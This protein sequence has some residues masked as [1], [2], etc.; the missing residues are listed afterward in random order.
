M[1]NKKFN[2]FALVMIVIMALFSIYSAVGKND[3][4][5]GRDGM[6]AY[7]RAVELGEFSGSEFEYLQSLHGKNGSN[8]TL[9]DVYE[10]YIKEKKYSKDDYTFSD[11]VL[12]F[13]P[14]EILDADETATLV[15]TST[16]SALRSTVDICYSFY[17]NNAIVYVEEATDGSGNTVFKINESSSYYQK[18]VAIGVSAGSG[19]IYK[20]DGLDTSDE[21]DDVAYIITNYHVLYAQNYTNNEDNY[22]VYYNMTTNEYFTATYDESKIKEGTEYVYGGIFGQQIIGT[23]TVH[24]FEKTDVVASPIET[25]FLTNYGVYLYGYQSSEYELSASFVGGSADNDIAVLK[26]ERDKSSNNQ[27]LFDGNYKAVDLGNS[28]NLDVGEKIIAVGNPLI[29]DTSNVNDSTNAS[30][31][32]D[33]LKQSYVDALCLTSTDGVI[34]NISEISKFDS[35]LDSSKAVDMRLIR[36]SAAINAGNSGGGLYDSY[37]RLVGI[38]NGKIASEKYDNV[39]FAIPVNV[40]VRLADRIIAECDGT[41]TQI[42]V[43]KATSDSLGITVKNGM[44]NS[45]YDSNKLVW[46]TAHNVVVETSSLLGLTSG[47]VIQSISFDDEETKFDLTESY[48]MNDILIMAKKGQTQKIVLHILQDGGYTTEFEISVVEEDFV[49]ID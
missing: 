33:S 26:I 9:E 22:R 4:K 37:G 36:V 7:E 16:Q 47:S 8:V 10:A 23:T 38:V 5:D 48:D 25:H 11:F 27:R 41:K 1:D 30:I 34:S 44:S 12:S 42:A 19:V 24:Y 40:A 6:S 32:V 46:I 17:M 49:L 15:Q 39:G 18:Y 31:Y 13:Y 14:N 20:I 21:S 28:K 43:L 35:I 3:A 2:A 29:A 45:Y